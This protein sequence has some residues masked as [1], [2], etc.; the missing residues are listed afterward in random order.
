MSDKFWATYICIS[1]RNTFTYSLDVKILIHDSSTWCPLNFNI[2]SL[3]LSTRLNNFVQYY[4]VHS[5][6]IDNTLLVCITLV[7]RCEFRFE[8]NSI[9]F[10]HLSLFFD[11][12]S[13]V[14]IYS[15]NFCVSKTHSTL[16]FAT[17]CQWP[18]VLFWYCTLKYRV[19][20]ILLHALYYQ[21]RFFW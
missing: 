8:Y 4:I 3:S 16:H 20:A 11:F 15:C 6:W 19:Q 2:K 5:F 7:Q 12:A 17:E 18:F 9:A 10:C 1:G 14:I 21:Y 13:L